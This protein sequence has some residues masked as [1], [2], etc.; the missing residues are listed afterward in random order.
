[1]SMKP[2]CPVCGTDK[3]AILELAAKV[4]DDLAQAYVIDEENQDHLSAAVLEKA[5]ERI[6]ELEP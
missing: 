5:A 3:R 4:C 1:M 2:P 6:R